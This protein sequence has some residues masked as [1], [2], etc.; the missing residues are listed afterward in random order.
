NELN[1]CAA[2]ALAGALGGQRE[3]IGKALNNFT[4]L[5]HRAQWVAQVGSV[6]FYND[7][8]ATNVGAAVAALR[9]LRQER[10]VLI[11]GGRD[12][13][14]SY[15]PLVSALS[16]RGRALV[17]LGE[18]ADKIADAARS[19]VPVLHA[20]TMQDAVQKAWESACDGD[21]VLLSPAC[22]SFDMFKSYV[23]RGDAFC[24]AVNVLT[25]AEARSEETR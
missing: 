18:A 9:G 3:Q 20:K 2:I 15:A 22:S 8:K 10:A 7:S 19:A 25:K 11:A 21:A 17:V 23:E 13:L 16:E 6:V 1:A 4:G 24:R 12:K 5:K 14:G